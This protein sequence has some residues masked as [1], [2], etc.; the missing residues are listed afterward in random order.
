M[1]G[2]APSASVCMRPSFLTDGG[3][4]T[5]LERHAMAGGDAMNAREDRPGRGDDVEVKVVEDGLGIMRGVLS[6]DNVRTLVNF[7]AFGM[8]AITQRTYG[9]PVNGEKDA[10]RVVPYGDGKV[11]PNLRRG[12][13]V[14]A[15]EGS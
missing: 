3:D 1:S 6:R 14:I 12:G 2:A 13:R 9:K 4:P 5:A 8:R 7:D 10:S 15:I 11:S